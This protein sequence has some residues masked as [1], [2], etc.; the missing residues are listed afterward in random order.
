[1]TRPQKSR[2]VNA[3]LVEDNAF[4]QKRFSRLLEA[5]G[6]DF[7]LRQACTIAEACDVMDSIKFDLIFVDMSIGS[8]NGLDLLPI[9]R[10]HRTN[11][12]AHLIMISGNGDTATAL[13][14][15]NRGFS[16][17]IDKGDLNIASLTRASLNALEKLRLTRAADEA[18]AEMRAV[19]AVLRS[20]S[21]A[22]SSEM[23]PMINRMIRQVR[24]LKSSNG[25]VSSQ[26]AHIAEI[27]GTCLRLE[28]F[29][30]DM[31][32]LAEDN[33]LTK[34]AMEQAP[35]I[36]DSLSQLQE[37]K[38]NEFEGLLRPKVTKPPSV[39]SRSSRG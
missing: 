35:D 28:E 37:P 8:D 12:D 19:E 21:K 6:L 33:Q 7:I 14:A 29:F 17:Y 18:S 11:A 25:S 32:A 23:R 10:A 39:F 26:S 27:E 16:D 3:L 4:D 9:V 38:P 30:Q 15:I 20:F 24:Q 1:M 36:L 34:I 2:Y 31:E 22:C 13:E 5:T